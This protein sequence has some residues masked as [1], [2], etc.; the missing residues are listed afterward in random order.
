[1]DD[2]K[3]LGEEESTDQ[4]NSRRDSTAWNPE[5]TVPLR[6]DGIRHVEKGSLTESALVEAKIRAKRVRNRDE[7]TEEERW[8]EKR[9]A[10]RL[11]AFQSRQRRKIIIDDLQVS[12]RTAIH[13]DTVVPKFCLIISF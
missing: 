3:P 4:L 2:F 8:T 7:M 11:A 12:L 9:A 13:S 6:I 10:N 1:M 5:S